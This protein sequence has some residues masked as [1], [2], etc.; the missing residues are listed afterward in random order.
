MQSPIHI[1]EAAVNRTTNQYEPRGS[2]YVM[3]MNYQPVVNLTIKHH[4]GYAMSISPNVKGAMGHLTTGC[5][6][7][8]STM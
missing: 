4:H 6:M 3:N 2:K 8:P 5:C 7:L 1:E